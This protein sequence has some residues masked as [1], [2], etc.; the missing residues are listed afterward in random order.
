MSNPTNT[1]RPQGRPVVPESEQR[2]N[3]LSVRFSD[4]ELEDLRRAAGGFP[5]SIW[6]RVAAMDRARDSE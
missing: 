3:V 2:S 5:V 6:V 1:K 4:A